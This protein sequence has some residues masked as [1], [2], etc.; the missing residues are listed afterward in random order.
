MIILISVDVIFLSPLLK[1][2]LVVHIHCSSSNKQLH[3]HTSIISLVSGIHYH[4]LNLNCC[5]VWMPTHG[6][7]LPC[8]REAG[9][10]SDPFAVA[11][12]KDSTT[13]SHVLRLISNACSLFLR[14]NGSKVWE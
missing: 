2:A 14:R 4:P 7:I 1:L 12:M 3:I 11:V 13:V 5:D 8:K 9:N 6:E 10:W